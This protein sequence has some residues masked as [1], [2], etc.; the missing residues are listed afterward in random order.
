QL[1]VVRSDD[2]GEDDFE[3][4]G[5]GGNG[6]TAATH[7]A[8]FSNPDLNNPPISTPLTIGQERI[9]GGDL[10]IAV[11][12][13]NAN[14]VVVVYTNAPGDNGPSTGIIQLVVTESFNGGTTWNEKFET[15]DSIRSGQ[16][17][18]AILANGAIGLLYNSYAP[19]GPD[20]NADGTLS[21]HLLTTTDDFVTSRDVTLASQDNPFPDLQF[22]PYLGDYFDL[23][24]SGNTFYGIFSASNADNGTDASF[25]NV[26]FNRD[27]AG[28][29]GT[30]NFQ[31]TDAN[32][33]E[34]PFSID[35][36]FFA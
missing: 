29:P 36:F 25:T 28:T 1:V 33:R 8:V 32:G 15:S 13:N 4:L 10:A 31:L 16:P 23:T 21:Q 11:D 27:F 34:V 19:G 6:V 5:P 24:G 20:P 35:P 18:V 22:H 26:T 30:S 2:G 17:G 14:H 9:A 7:I 3:A 12:P